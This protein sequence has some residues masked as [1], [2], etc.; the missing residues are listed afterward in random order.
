MPVHNLFLDFYSHRASKSHIYGFVIACQFFLSDFV[1][2][3]YIDMK[4]TDPGVL[5]E[6]GDVYKAGV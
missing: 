5:T 6:M 3:D 1:R 2:R 4:L